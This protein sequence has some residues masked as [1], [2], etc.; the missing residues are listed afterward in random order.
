MPELPSK[1]QIKTAASELSKI[2]N[3]PLRVTDNQLR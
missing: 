2:I 3:L 1:F